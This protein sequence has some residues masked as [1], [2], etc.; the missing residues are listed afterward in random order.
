MVFNLAKLIKVKEVNKVVLIKIEDIVSNPSQPRK[1]FEH[2]RIA[3]LAESIKQNGLLQPVSVRRIN[4]NKYE[5]IAGERRALAYRFL[6]EEYI[7]AIVDYFTDEQSAVLALIENLQ[8]QNLNYFEEAVA[9]QRLV[10][11][12]GLTQR[13]LSIKLGKAQSTIANKLRILK[14]PEI[15]REK[16]LLNSLTERHAR[17][18]LKI[19]D[20]NK[21]AAI[22]DYIINNDLNVEET[23]AYIENVNNVNQQNRKNIFIIKDFRIFI[24]SINKAVKMMNTAGINVKSERKEDEEYFHYVITVPKDKVSITDR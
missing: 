20:S 13:D 24:N 9:I 2:S 12:Y 1:D 11:E 5:L 22:I 6:N 19:E 7:P 21:L 8:R 14:I 23:E 15:F 17:A 16:M 10:D 3:E 4:N 18:L